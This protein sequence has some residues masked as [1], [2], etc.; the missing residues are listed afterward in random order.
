VEAEPSNSP[1]QVGDV[2]AGKYRVDRTLCRGGIGIVVAAHHLA[3]DEAVALKFIGL[4]LA[5][6]RE[7]V[8]RLLREARATFRLRSKHTVRVLDADE[9]PSGA[10]YI[11]MELL[12]GR[13][14]RTELAERG[15]LPEAEVISYVL[16]A[17]DALEEAH[18]LGIVHRDLKP[19][20]LFLARQRRGPHI[21]KVLDF[22]MSKVDPA[23]FEAGPLTLP[24]TA[25]GTPRYMAPEQ[26]RSAATVDHRAD[27]WAL[28]VVMYELMT[29]KVPLQGM[30]LGERQARL[31]AGAIPSPGALHPHISEDTARVIMRC[32]KADPVSRWRSVAHLATALRDASPTTTPDV[33][34]AE[35]TQTAVT[36]VVPTKQMRE[37]AARAFATDAPASELL[38]EPARRPTLPDTP[39]AIDD[40]RSA[41]DSNEVTIVR[42]PLFTPPELVLDSVT[43]PV[44][45]VQIPVDVEA[46]TARGEPPAT[47]ERK[48]IREMTL[49]SAG[50]L[51][52]VQEMLDSPVTDATLRL[53]GAPLHP[54][55]APAPAAPPAAAPIVPPAPAW[56]QPVRPAPRKRTSPVALALVVALLAL[57]LGGLAAWVVGR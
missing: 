25:L 30:P 4:N 17:C 57:V 47:E 44:A 40:A 46:P 37:Q 18:T 9:L 10:A 31:L 54:S 28:G 29:G 38:P 51:P 33:E 2:V 16:Q 12:D 43:S 8:Q 1:V 13:D 22:G 35:V 27:V 19:H 36:A 3:L 15:P 42:A 14:L 5:A 45:E 24:E 7:V 41:P 50:P 11:V 6:E 21:V 49:R 52:G 56:P 53:P 20:N 55:N 39:V 32:L 48:A 26:W 34:R 23:L